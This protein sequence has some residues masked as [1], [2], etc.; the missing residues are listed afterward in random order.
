MTFHEKECIVLYQ[1]DLSVIPKR[2]KERNLAS[3]LVVD[4]L[5]LP[6]KEVTSG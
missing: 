1:G 3:L 4:E 5:L 6:L 2:K